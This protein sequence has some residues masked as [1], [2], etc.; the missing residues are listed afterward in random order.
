MLNDKQ[1]LAK[2]K[3]LDPIALEM[4]HQRFYEPVARYIQFKVSD[5]QTAEDLSS[6]V[7]VRVLDGLKQGRSWKTS[8]KGWIMGIAHH[9]VV[10]H[11]RHKERIQEV[12]LTETLSDSEEN[13]PSYQFMVGERKRALMQAIDHLTDE[14]RDVI[15]MRFIEGINIEGVAEALQ[16]SPGAVKGLQYRAMRVLAKKLVN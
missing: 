5:I 8:A 7:F 1:L 13:N 10:D 4:L 2:A 11:Y 3:Q 9:V 12:I 14:Q 15:L 16:K 6:E